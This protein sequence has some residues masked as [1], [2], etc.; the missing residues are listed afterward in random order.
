MLPVPTP[1]YPE[2]IPCSSP[3]FSDPSPKLPVNTYSR[4]PDSAWCP[5]PTCSCCV[6]GFLLFPHV[7]GCLLCH[8]CPLCTPRSSESPYITSCLMCTPCLP[9]CPRVTHLSLGPP[10][11]PWLQCVPILG[12]LRSPTSPHVLCDP[13]SAHMPPISTVSSVS[14]HIPH[15][16]HAFHVPCVSPH[17]PHPLSLPC[18][19][20][21]CTS[22][23]FI[24][25]MSPVSPYTLSA[26]PVFLWFPHVPV[27]PVPTVPQMSLF[28]PCGTAPQV[29]VLPQDGWPCCVAVWLWGHD[30]KWRSLWDLE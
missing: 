5:Q 24:S 22:S 27:L 29:W 1:Q 6:P 9:A 17:A 11:S 30:V 4:F 20:H 18:T 25:P 26:S 16:P 8:P 7:P 3:H 21:P 2:P 12:V 23:C 13:H 19:L 28:S 10:R 14:P 15:V